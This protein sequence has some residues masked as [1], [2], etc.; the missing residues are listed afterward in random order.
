MKDFLSAFS[1]F[2]QKFRIEITQFYLQVNTDELNFVAFVAFFGTTASL[3]SKTAPQYMKMYI[4]IPLPKQ[5]FLFSL[6]W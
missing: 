5:K 3:A 1:R 4:L 6:I 2:S